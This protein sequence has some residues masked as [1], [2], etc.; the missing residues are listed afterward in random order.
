MSQVISKPQSTLGQQFLADVYSKPNEKR[1][2]L[3]DFHAEVPYLKDT[4]RAC[5]FNTKTKKQPGHS[6]LQIV[7]YN[8][9]HC[10]NIASHSCVKKHRHNIEAFTAEEFDGLCEAYIQEKKLSNSKN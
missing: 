8:C 3:Q 1:L 6:H 2:D 4:M 9:A 5:M 7:Y 10:N